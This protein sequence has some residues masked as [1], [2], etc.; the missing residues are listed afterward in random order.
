HL[1]DF[2]VRHGEAVAIGIALDS[3]YS[4]LKGLLSR[5]DLKRI[6]HLIKTLGFE[7]YVP[8]LSGEALLEGLEEFREHLGGELT[9]MLL[10]GIGQ[11]REVHEMD[12]TLVLEAVQRL[13]SYRDEIIEV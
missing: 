1:T 2:N 7:L 12:K 8:E 13:K 3:T 10:E 4:W 5:E 9:I 11:G 6:I